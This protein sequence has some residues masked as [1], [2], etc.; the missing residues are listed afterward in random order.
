MR[1]IQHST[2]PVIPPH[3]LR[4]VT[5]HGDDEARERVTATLRH[6]VQI[7]ENRSQLVI[8]APPGAVAALPAKHRAVYDARHRR[9]LPG[10]LALDDHHTGST[11]I[12]ATEAFDGCGATHDFFAKAFGRNSIDDKGLTLV[13][14]VHY[15]VNFDN[16][17]W[18]G[19]QMI[20]GDG[21]GKLFN[22]FTIALDV[23]GHELTHGVTEHDAALEYR[24]QSGALNEHISDAFGIM[25][26]QYALGQLASQSD[27]LIGAGLLGPNVR[28]KAVRSMKAPGTAYDDLVIGRDPQPAHMRHYV[29]SEDDNGGVHINSGIPNHAFYLFATAVGGPVWPVAGRIWYHVL[30]T[31][32]F[33]HA[34]FQDFASATVK[35]A[36]EM[37]GIGSSV[38]LAAADAWSAVGLPLPPSMTRKKPPAR[39]RLKWRNRPLRHRAA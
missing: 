20:Y 38:Q 8:E 15:G 5:E 29:T 22:R 1:N 30:K 3:I 39:N 34:G 25:V 4:Y 17:M 23:I 32:L 10:K 19:R 16:A 28:G 27:W 37:Y 12:E 36:G 7:A 26:K 13:S 9:T 33:P 14:T 6:T 35:T 21:D 18:N 24:N 2:C 11:D 31:Q